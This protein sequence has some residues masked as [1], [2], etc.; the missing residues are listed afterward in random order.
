MT[1]LAAPRQLYATAEP[2]DALISARKA[3]PAYCTAKAS[4]QAGDG[5]RDLTPLEAMFAYY[6][7][8]KAGDGPSGG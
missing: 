2:L 5:L 7:S 8:D 6:G 1:A 3:T 4:D